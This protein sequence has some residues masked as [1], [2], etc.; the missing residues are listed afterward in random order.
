MNFVFIAAGDVN[1]ASSR[2]RVFQLGKA[3]SNLGHRISYE[4]SDKADVVFIQK[5]VDKSLLN[6]I[7]VQKYRGTFIIYD[8]DDSGP[9]LNFWV[10]EENFKIIIGLADIIT[11]DTQS[12]IDFLRDNYKLT[13][14]YLLPDSIDYLPVGIY[15]KQRELILPIRIL[16]FGSLSNIHLFEKYIGV[17]QTINDAQIVVATSPENF[18]FLRGKYPFIEFLPWSVDGFIGILHSCDVSILMHD[19]TPEDIL[20]SN[21]RMITSIAWGLPAVVSNTPEYKKTALEIDLSEFVF[22]NEGDIIRIITNLKNQGTITRYLVKSQNIIWN[23]YNSVCISLNLISL[24]NKNNVMKNK[25]KRTFYTLQKVFINII[26][27]KIYHKYFKKQQQ[28]GFNSESYMIK[29]DIQKNHRKRDYEID[30]INDQGKEY[31]L[32]VYKRQNKN[33][34]LPLLSNPTLEEIKSKID[35]YKPEKILEVGCGWGRIMEELHDFYKIE[36]CDVC[37]DY[38]ELCNPKLKTFYYDIA[39]ENQD[40]VKLNFQKWDIIFTR[41]VMLYFME[42]PEQMAYA[43]N[44]MLMLASKGIIIWEWPEVC[45]KMKFF[46]NSD[47]FEYC[48]ILHLNE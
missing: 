22:R 33:G 4:P 31:R 16:W 15:Q 21:N 32:N 24:I 27:R 2:I 29:D 20:K 38:L 5:K 6:Y 36:G 3:L 26:T 17:L 37:K 1:T 10:S 44:N 34:F 48:P 8:L 45:E 40:F 7:K 41:G 12:R 11:T 39:I 43:M 13:N 35:I 9:A 47:K 23:K 42:N 14:V 25:I 19:G 18:E 28:R 30:W 46:S